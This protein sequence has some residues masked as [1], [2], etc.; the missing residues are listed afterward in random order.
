MRKNILSSCV[1][2]SLLIFSNI[3]FSQTLEL[4]VLSSF[5]TFAGVGAVTNGGTSNGNAGTNTGIISGSGF[6]KTNIFIGTIYN[7]DSTTI[8]ARIDLL[9]VYIHLDDI[10]VTYPSTHAPAFGGGETITP[11]VY[12]IGG[13]GSIAGGLTLD[14]G[15]DSNAV[16][17]MKFEGAFTVGVGS[18]ITLSGGT[19]AANVFWISQGAISVGAS[20]T[21]KGTLFAH[22]GAVTLGANSNIEGR[23]LTSEGAITIAAGG[24]AVMPVGPIT[25]PIQCLGNC[26]SVP[27]LD[28]LR[29][30]KKYALFT[31]NGAVANAATSGI[32][33]NI[34]TNLG[35]ISGFGTSTHVGYTYHPGIETAKA[36]LDLD[37][38]YNDLIALPNTELGHTPAFGS[39]ETVYTGVYYIG[40]AGSLAGT[41]IL[42]GQNNPNSIF[43]FKFNG[44]FSVAAQSRVILI[45]GASRCNV[46][47]ISEG[48]SDMGT[49]TY[50]KGTVLAHGGACSMGANGSMEGRML[51]TAGAIGFSTGVVYNDGLCFGDDT[52]VPGPDQTVCSDGTSTQ[53]ITATATSNTTNGTIIWYDAATGGA[54]VSNPTQIGLGTKTYYAESFNGTYSS[55]TRASVTLIIKVCS[56]GPKSPTITHPNIVVPEDSSVV[57]CPTLTDPD[58]P[59]DSL[60]I[61]SCNTQKHGTLLV[62]GGTCFE[63][64][65]DFNFV[66]VDSLCLIVCDTSGLCDTTVV[67]ISV[68]PVI[69]TL[70]KVIPED[71]TLVVCPPESSLVN[72][73]T[74]LSLSCGAS[75]GTTLLSFKTGCVTYVPDSNYVGN[76]KICIVICD[77]IAGLCD[78]TVV[79]I[80]VT[81]VID[82][83]IDTT[84]Y[85]CPIT[86]CSPTIS[87]MDSVVFFS[88]C[89]A[90]HGAGN[91][92]LDPITN[93]VTYSPSIGL[94]GY[95]TTCFVLCNSQGVC[96]TTIVI[97]KI[98][99]S[100]TID[101]IFTRDT[102]VCLDTSEIIRYHTVSTC[103][104]L[105]LTTNGGAVSLLP[106]GCV[107]LSPN[108]GTGITDTTCIIICDTLTDQCDTT[109]IVSL[110]STMR[111]TIAVQLNSSNLGDICLTQ[112]EL[113][114]ST[115]SYNSCKRPVHGILIDYNDTC[116]NYYQSSAIKYLDTT[117]IVICDEYGFCDTTVLIFVPNPESDT[118]SVQTVP[119]SNAD[120]CVTLESTFMSGHTTITCD[121]MGIS[122]NGFPL[123]I[124]GLCISYP[125]SGAI[126]TGDTACILVCDT[127]HG[128]T[129]CDTTL[130]VYLPDTISP[131]VICKNDTIY[132]DSSGG[133]LLDTSHVVSSL[134]DNTLINSVW[135]SNTWFDCT[136]LGVN[137]VTLTVTDTNRNVGSCISTVTILDTIVPI[138]V[139]KDTTIYLDISNQVVI[140][141]SFVFTSAFDNCGVD[142]VWINKAIF[143]CND[144]GS[145]IVTVSAFDRSGNAGSCIST[146]TV[147]L[148]NQPIKDTIAVQINASNFAQICLTD[149]RLLGTPTTYSLCKGVSRGNLIN[150]NDTCF[151]YSQTSSVK[152]LD[153]ACV[154]VC[155]DCGICDTTVL[156]FVPT[157]DADT[158]YAGPVVPVSNVDTCVVLE[159]T[160]MAGHHVGTCDSPGTSSTGVPLTLT[161]LCVRYPVPS[162]VFTGDSVCIIV[163]DTIHG[164]TICDTTL[165]VYIP[166]TIPPTVVCKTGTVYLDNLGT[167]TIDTSHVV[168]SVT[169]NT[170]INAVWLSNTLFNCSNV[171]PNT[172]TFYV[173]DTNRNIDSCTT[174]ITVLDTIAPTVVCQNITISLDSNGNKSIVALDIDGGSSD[175]CAIATLT[176]DKRAFDCSN[177]GQNSVT[178][179]VT[180]I[181]GN[182]SNCIAIVTVE[183]GMAPL[184]LCPADQKRV[185]RNTTCTYLVEDFTGLATWDDNCDSSTITVTQFPSAGTEVGLNN[186]SVTVT[187]TATDGS[188]NSS[189]CTFEVYSRCVKELRVTQF[190]SPNGDGLND[191]W[192]IP[193]LANYPNNVVKVFNRWGN[194]VLEEK[195]YSGG[196]NGVANINGSNNTLGSGMLPEGTY[197]YIIDLGDEN[198]EP[199]VGY[200]Q[201]KR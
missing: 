8:Q 23:L 200:M 201:I 184:V 6:D 27:A 48:A 75:H 17:I 43:V 34:G 169:D 168:S 172:V 170:L 4:G 29:S 147:R 82:T 31:S 188:L 74:G 132:L 11:G 177:I 89:S 28:V 96:D 127:I 108:F 151:T 135:L 19:R 99:V 162:A 185:V 183:D 120:T 71:S 107:M 51:S 33:G 54:V 189:I 140:D 101:T 142:S 193:E 15:G 1:V 191:T 52:P 174:T 73:I 98:D 100:V 134:T 60:F 146:V 87:S 160:F 110:K 2:V 12:S 190:I 59:N 153:T 158:I 46:F 129:V 138:V 62:V 67:L 167:V 66:G 144:L 194:R 42:D 166:D 157:P 79:L 156:I 32:V 91:M 133:M 35:A 161:G 198:F 84:C 72:T 148:L 16:F 171:G 70:I 154:I 115:Y 114:G 121:G 128:L 149:N 53:A 181:Y 136:N 137:T 97:V 49:F 10:F 63:Y 26:I 176:I 83:L 44:A 55:T 124:T 125:V 56:I 92:T 20:S 81:P 163:C 113:F 30:L 195:G 14:G 187:I 37:S 192:E 50:M 61:S 9:R 173:R 21:I 105:G 93:C 116:F 152:Y 77:N 7:N 94:V 182:S 117:C 106:H 141:S 47:W 80:S 13:A 64:K 150:Y 36:V 69:D 119:V 103:D 5:E 38:A 88:S 58:L 131:R 76:D 165:I 18:A 164:L 143:T 180:D 179:T 123:T 118:L 24:V 199:Y 186:E 78:T 126:F 65:P 155:D 45:N 25:V 68:T 112:D 122:S 90:H 178:L 3:N 22:P 95:D 85:T 139:C 130:I 145:K 175:N 40:G 102:I 196:W 159:S 57:F 111:D 86:W 41:I 109:I 197:F 39:G 104:G